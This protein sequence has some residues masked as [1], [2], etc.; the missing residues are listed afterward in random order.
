[1]RVAA[2]RARCCGLALWLSLLAALPA[3][4]PGGD[5]CDFVDCDCD[6]FN[7]TCGTFDK[8]L[9]QDAD[10]EGRVKTR[11]VTYD[12]DHRVTCNYFYD[13]DGACSKVD[14]RDDGDAQCV[15]EPFSLF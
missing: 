1:M 2:A 9:S 7:Y 12:N 13:E 6:E 3:C 11:R 8:T 4:G 10:A 14:C 5:G 15:W